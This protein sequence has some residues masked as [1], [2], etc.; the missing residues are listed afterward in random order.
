MTKT[1]EGPTE[2]E[3]ND[4]THTMQ[5]AEAT[6][7]TEVVWLVAQQMEG[8]ELEVMQD[9]NVDETGLKE[10]EGINSL[11]RLL[12]EEEQELLGITE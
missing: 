8:E 1:K 11:K 12:T 5:P 7:S 3:M 6:V 10:I 4:T 2:L 9:G